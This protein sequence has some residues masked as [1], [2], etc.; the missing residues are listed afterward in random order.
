MS[1]VPF[2]S[3]YVLVPIQE[4]TPEDVKETKPDEEDELPPHR[5]AC[6]VAGLV[7]FLGCLSFFMYIVYYTL[8]RYSIF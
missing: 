1:A 2:S 4:E 5:I 6:R 8:T 7:S 3:D